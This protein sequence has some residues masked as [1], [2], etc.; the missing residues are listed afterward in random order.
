M[1]RCRAPQSCHNVIQQANK[2][3]VTQINRTPININ[4][5]DT[6]FEA[7]EVC[8][9]K[10]YG[11]KIDTQNDPSAFLTGALVAVQWEDRGCGYMD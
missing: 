10:N 7:L 8:Q 6:Q 4:T 5:N 11:Q 3:L 2:R 1:P 9:K